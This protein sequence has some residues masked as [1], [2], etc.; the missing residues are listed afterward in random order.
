MPSSSVASA[1]NGADVITHELKKA[2]SNQA[3]EE[4]KSTS[5]NWFKKEE[6]S[7]NNVP[8]QRQKTKKEQQEF[9]GPLQDFH[10]EIN[11]LFDQ[12]FRNF[13]FS[14]F[15]INRPF[16]PSVGNMLRP[17]TDLSANDKEYTVTVEVPGAEKDD[18]KIEVANNIM[19]IRGE[20]KQKKEEK[21]KDYYR[22]ERF[23][24]SFQRV[25][26]LPKDADQTDIKATFK[27]GVLTVTMPRKKMP[28]SDVKK[29]EIH[30]S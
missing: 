25:F 29:I 13:G 23:Y 6:E 1:A 27:Q 18:I 8:V 24:G 28:K 11:R 15:D 14:S 26:S 9:A 3:T 20:K 16:L 12:T 7:D 5:W 10:R 4:K 2:P 22:Q 21:E 19:T 30:S 17:M